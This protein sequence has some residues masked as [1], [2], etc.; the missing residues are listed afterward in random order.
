MRIEVVVRPSVL[1]D[2]PVQSADL[3]IYGRRI[4]II[5]KLNF[6]CSPGNYH[7]CSRLAEVLRNMDSEN[8]H[9]KQKTQNVASALTFLEQYQKMAIKFS[10]HSKSNT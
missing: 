4:F 7:S 10:S 6:D 9:S 1:S 8:D 5:P 3:E 2:D